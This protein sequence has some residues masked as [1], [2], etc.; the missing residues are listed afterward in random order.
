MNGAFFKLCAILRFVVA[1]AAEAELGALFL[2]CKQASFFWLTLEEMGHPQP[3]TTIH[4]D[5]STAVGIAN[6]TVKRQQS[7]LMEMRF[8]WVADAVAQ[9]FFDIK[10]YPGKKN[11]ADY[12]IKHHTG[13][14]HK[15]VQPWYLHKPS[16]VR[17]LPRAGKPSTLKGC[18]GT[19]PDGYLRSNPLPQVPTRQRL[20]IGNSLPLYLEI[21]PLGIPNLHRIGQAIA[22]VAGAQIIGS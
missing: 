21:S 1:S 11:L 22:R 7:G 14:H 3:P 20:P 18:V 2:N 5:I 9:G 10:Y 8:F 16:S 4:C 15:A 17:E 19:L 12:Q 13:A 6:N